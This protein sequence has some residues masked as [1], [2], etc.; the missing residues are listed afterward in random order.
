MKI[1]QPQATTKAPQETFT[2][3][4]WYDVIAEHEESPHM[5]VSIVR[6]APGARNAWHSHVL[7]QTLYVT[8]GI[9]LVQSRGGDVTEI[10]PGDV[11]HT[12]PGEWHWHGAT[13]DQFMTHIA[14]WEVDD[15]GGAATWGSLVTDE[16][17]RA[18]PTRNRR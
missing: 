11:V 6:F 18:Q 3:D 16:E 2:G 7:G 1:K 8:E 9:G 5:R 14:M 17:Y 4:A 13:P 12:P 15:Q 10:R